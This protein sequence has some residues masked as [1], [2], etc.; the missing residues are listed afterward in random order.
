MEVGSDLFFSIVMY[1]EC[2]KLSKKKICRSE[3]WEL[4][5]KP[6][7]DECELLAYDTREFLNQFM[8]SKKMSKIKHMH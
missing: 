1:L 7:V 5:S 2:K 4:H 3:M 8:R 6:K